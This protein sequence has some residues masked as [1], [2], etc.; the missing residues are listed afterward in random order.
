MKC[1][2]VTVPGG[3]SAIVCG[4]RTRHRCKCGR[5]ADLLCDWKVK[6]KRSG[7]CDRPICS[8]CTT[9]PAP[10]KDLCL[11]HAAEYERWKASR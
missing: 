9:K 4:T 2:H 8:R 11:E 5:A 6:G 10:D 1:Q 7:T 3:Y